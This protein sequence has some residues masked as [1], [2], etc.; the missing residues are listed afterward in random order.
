MADRN[1]KQK[2]FWNSPFSWLFS[3]L[4]Y[5]VLSLTHINWIC[6]FAYAFLC[7]K[8]DISKYSVNELKEVSVERFFIAKNGITSKFIV[9]RLLISICSLLY[10]MP[11]SLVELIFDVRTTIFLYLS[12]SKNVISKFICLQIVGIKLCSIITLPCLEDIGVKNI[13]ILSYGK[14]HP[15]MN[16]PY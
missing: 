15:S 13:I 9:F 8:F 14:S 4:P 5:K 11:T 12:L 2:D 6:E 10:E 7:R 3:Q 16:A 1:L